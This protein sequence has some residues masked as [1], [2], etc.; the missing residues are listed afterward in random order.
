MFFL[1]FLMKKGKII[2]NEA[3]CRRT[4]AAAGKK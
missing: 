2:K 3:L 4:K 1:F